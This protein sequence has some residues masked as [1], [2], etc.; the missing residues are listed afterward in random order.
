MEWPFGINRQR[1][2]DNIKND[3]QETEWQTWN[4]LIWLRTV[5]C[6]RLLQIR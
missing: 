3:L 6:G 5:T 2:V 4:G 1:S